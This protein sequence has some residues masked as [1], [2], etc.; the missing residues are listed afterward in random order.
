MATVTF[1][2]FIQQHVSCPPLEVLGNTA[3]DVLQAYFEKHRHV[4]GYILDDHGCLRPRLSLYV[5]GVMATDR[6]GLSNPVHAHAQVHIG[7]VP[8]DTEYETL[9]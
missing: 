3:R 7:H 1:T 4:R 8:L 9:D 6:T 5:D 2:P